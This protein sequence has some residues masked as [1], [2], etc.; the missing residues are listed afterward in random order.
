MRG[1]DYVLFV[2]DPCDGAD[3]A[4]PFSYPA[5][6]T[7]NAEVGQLSHFGNLFIRKSVSDYTVPGNGLFSQLGT[8][9]ILVLRGSHTQLGIV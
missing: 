4:N 1:Q 3:P 2:R 8:D 7:L 9:P 6:E 5:K